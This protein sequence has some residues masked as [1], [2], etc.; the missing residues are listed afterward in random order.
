VART[1]NGYDGASRLAVV[2]DTTNSATYS[3]LANSSLVGQIAFK[4]N[5]VARMS[6]SKQ[7]DYLNR[8]TSISS[9]PSNAFSYLYNAANQRTMAWNWDGSYWRYGYDALGQVIQGE[10]YW[11][12]QTMG[13]LGLR[14][15]KGRYDKNCNH[16]IS[17]ALK[18][19]SCN[20]VF[21]F[22]A[23]RRGCT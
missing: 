10:K 23:L 9:T 12:D 17:T 16:R 8:L 6:T 18:R 1:T 14:I 7:Y 15:L 22:L 4:S 19:Y 20:G 21:R 3:Y 5:T 11:V 2:S 13:S